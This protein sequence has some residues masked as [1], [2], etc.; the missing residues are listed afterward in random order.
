MSQS[1]AIPRVIPDDWKRLDLIINKIKF[2]LGSASSPIFAGVTITGLTQGSVVFAGASGVISQDNSNLFWDDTI[3]RLGIG[4]N[5]GFFPAAGMTVS[6]EM[7]LIHTAGEPDDHA[8]EIDVDAAGRGDVKAID[9]DYITGDITKGEDEAVILINID[10]IGATGAADVFGLEVLATEG[11]A[12]IYGMKVGAVIG[13]I[14]QDSG[15]FENPTVATNDTPATNVP[16]M[17]DGLIANVTPIFS[18]VPNDDDYILI[19]DIAVFEEIEFIITT[20]SS[21][22][23]IKPKFEYS[24]AGSNL[25]TEFFPVD[26]TNGFRNTGVVA[27]DAGDLTNHGLNTDTTPDTYCIKITRQRTNLTTTPILGFAKVAATTEYIWD[28]GGNVN[29]KTLT[30]S[31][32]AA[33]GADVDKFLVDSSGVVKYRTGTEVLGDIGG[34][35]IHANLTSLATL[36]YAAAAFVKMTGANTFVLRTIGETADDLQG[37]IDHDLTANYV[38]NKH[39]DHTGVDIASGKGL[40]GGGDI[41]STRTLALDLTEMTGNVVWNDGTTDASI[42]WTYALSGAN[43]PVWTIGANSMD[44]TTGVLKV[45]GTTVMLVGGAPTAHLHDGDTLEHDGVNSSAGA[46]AFTTGGLVTFNSS[47]L[48]DTG[49]DITVSGH[50][51]FN[52]NNSYIGFADPRLTFDDTNNLIQVTGKL[53]LPDN[54]Y[55]G[56]ASATTALQIDSSGNVALSSN[57]NLNSGIGEL[58]CGSINKAANTLTLEI[59]GTPVISVL[60]THVNIDGTLYVRS[61]S[62]NTG[63]DG[64]VAGQ[65]VCYG[66]ASGTYGGRSYFHTNNDADDAIEFFHI[67]VENDD[68]HIGDDANGDKISLIGPTGYVKLADGA[69]MATS[70]APTTDAMI[71]NKKYVDDTHGGAPAAHTIVS[72]SDTTGTGAELNTLTGGGD[73]G[74]LHTHAAAYQP[75]DAD[76][77]AIAAGTWVGAASITTI[78]TLPSLLITSATGGAFAKMVSPDGISGFIFESG[79]NERSCVNFRE[80]TTGRWSI[81]NDGTDGDKFKIADANFLAGN[82]RVTILRSNGDVGIG[83]D[84]VTK[85]TVEGTLTLKEQANAGGDTAAYGQI[86]VK[87]DAPNILMFTDDEGNDFIVDITAV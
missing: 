44:L 14:H 53:T 33:E 11:L 34:Q 42:T 45:G 64:S 4:I 36:T 22:A 5:S 84:P 75:L 30:I 13:P 60:S 50:V 37:T 63:V 80:E 70:G 73:V 28:K 48:L 31:T 76:L 12:G 15:T 32:I 83:I 69:V 61:G 21:G 35:P 71:A 39:I 20:G 8:F 23:G 86:W 81:G 56:S 72:H 62:V 7:D 79:A 58:T 16:Y 46:F 51:V 52:T 57:L 10:E 6:G 27:W 74:A 67:R 49:A 85:L 77:T 68:L 25:F 65:W 26:G 59:A 38:A 18:S 41:S 1:L 9:I 66:A 55:L 47:I 82:V 19:G 29:I 3:N 2:H 17:I 43:D 40:S 87:N 54:G 24:R 78:G